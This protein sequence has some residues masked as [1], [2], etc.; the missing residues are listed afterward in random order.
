M[1]R[2]EG[3]TSESTGRNGVRSTFGFETPLIGAERYLRPSAD[4]GVGGPSARSAAQLS[5]WSATCPHIDTR[6]LCR[7]R[8]LLTRRRIATLPCP[9]CLL[10]R[11]GANGQPHQTADPHLLRIAG[12]VGT[13][14]HDQAR[15]DAKPGPH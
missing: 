11:L 13:Q 9:P 3:V 5:P 2:I 12:M 7:D 10:R 1:F 14:E 4:P 15:S 8:D 6:R